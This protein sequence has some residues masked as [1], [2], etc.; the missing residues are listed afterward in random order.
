M[1][2]L[3]GKVILLTGATDG[4]GRALAADLARA[5]ATVLVHGRDPGRIAATAVE[6]A[7]AAQEAGNSRGSTPAVRS[8]QADFASLAEVR[9]LAEQVLTAEPRLD[10]LVNNAGIGVT[11]PGD[12]ARQES[13]D[14]IELRFAVN[15]LAGYVL[16]RLL[17]PLL[18]SSAPSR[19]VNVASIGQQ[20]IEF[21][22]V[23]LTE[24]YDGMRAYRQSKLAQVM[25]AFDLAAELNGL[26]V[27]VTSLHP[28]T[29]MPTKVS[30]APPASTIAQGVAATF[31]LIAAPAEQ[32]G[33][34]GFFNGLEEGRANDQAY[35]SAARARLREISRELTGL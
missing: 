7:E 17:L 15:Y 18:V 26:G 8:Y 33:T 22:D 27:T 14:G 32:T 6:V 5:G 10:V 9:A 29:F 13:A 12:G 31:R 28:A 35:D 2:T 11:Q 24:G 21:G 30:P 4:M 25:N 20:A 1:T 3:D 34:G 23:Q 19:I 16:S